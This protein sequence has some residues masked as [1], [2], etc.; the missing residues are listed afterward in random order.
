LT[1][2]RR[3]TA[4]SPEIAAVC[5]SAWSAW[6]VTSAL[7][8]VSTYWNAFAAAMSYVEAPEAVKL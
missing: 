8:S 7:V 5:V 2:E 1:F 3:A 4:S 6:M